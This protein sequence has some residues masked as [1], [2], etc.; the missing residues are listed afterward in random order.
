VSPCLLGEDAVHR[1]RLAAAKRRCGKVPKSFP[2]INEQFSAGGVKSLGNHGIVDG[3]LTEDRQPEHESLKSLH[4]QNQPD[5]G[6]GK[7]DHDGDQ[8]H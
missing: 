5:H 4:D 7:R 6:G 2:K 1:M 8:H 3:K